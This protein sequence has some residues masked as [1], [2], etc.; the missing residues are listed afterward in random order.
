M[1]KSRQ[2]LVKGGPFQCCVGIVCFS[3]L[4]PVVKDTERKL[5]FDT[6]WDMKYIKSIHTMS[7]DIDY[8]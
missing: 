4:L 1:W 5:E 3:T 2:N 8:R 6:E 7:K